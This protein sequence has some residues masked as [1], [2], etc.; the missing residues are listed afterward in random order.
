MITITRTTLVLLA[1]VAVF[2]AVALGACGGGDGSAS[3][4]PDAVVARIDGREVHQSDVDQVLAEARLTGDDGDDGA[5]LDDA[6]DR[7]LVRA[8][9]E[10]LGLTADGA[11]VESRLAAVGERLGGDAALQA[12]LEQAAMSEAQ[13]RESLRIGVLREAVQDARFPDV[14][15]E[16]RTVR[17]FYERQR[18]DLFTTAAAVRLGAIVVRNEGIAGNAIKRLRLGRPFR[19]VARQF[20]IDPEIKAAEGMMG[21]I[22]P[23]SLPGA[24]GTTVERLRTGQ[25]SAPV[26]GPG[27]TWVV[28][29]FS[30]RPEQVIPFARVRTDIEEGLTGRRRS[31][32]LDKWLVEARKDATIERL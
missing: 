31:A 27:G 14:K 21:W 9:A 13:L 4:S 16:P 30:R 26:A 24:L 10:R 17:R 19:E 1:A 32:A 8:E 12:G 15:A 3:A 22:D 18:A 28:K 2:A 23:A 6:I 29:V 11:E 7:E 5:A 25:I 20:T